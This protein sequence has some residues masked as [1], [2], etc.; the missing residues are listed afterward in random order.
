MENK[1]E[2]GGSSLKPSVLVVDDEKRIRDGCQKALRT[3][4]YVV[5]GA[6]N[7]EVALEKIHKKHFDLVLLDLMMPGPSGLEVLPQIKEIDSDAVIIVITGYATLEHAIEAMKKGAFDFIAKPFTPDQLRVVASKA[8]EYSRALQDIA[9]ERSRVRTLIDRLAEGVVTTDNE[10]RIVL[11]N[12]SFL[13]MVGW[14]K[15]GDV[16]NKFLAEVTPQRELMDMMDKVLSMPSDEFAELTEE[17]ELNNGEKKVL[18]A[19]C[20]PFR[21]R[22]GRTL[23]A[24]TVLHDITAIREMDQLKSSFVSMVS[25]EI[26]SPMNSVLAQLKVVLDGLAGELT[27][28]QK[29]ILTRASQKI[30]GLS[31]LAA[32]LLDLARIEAGLVTQEKEKLDLGEIIEQQVAFYTEKAAEKNIDLSLQPLPGLP[33]VLGSK[34]NLEEVLSNLIS[35][36]IKYSPE[37]GR[38]TVSAKQEDEF[39]ELKVSDTGYGIPEEDLERIFEKFY[40]VKNEDTRGISGTGLGLAIVKSIVEAHNGTI[41][42]ESELGKGTTFT[43]FLPV[44]K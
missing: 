15:K 38:V 4:G 44:M 1:M 33:P 27:P 35:N 16:T 42:V 31:E 24:V 23:G 43:V 9:E 17:L 26:Q 12:P 2:T 40:R 21:D 7:G 13:R 30:K 14:K 5:D 3:K 34:Y 18:A 39:I 22:I 28:K 36:A 19:R 10:K 6:E 29:D 20:V 25:H 8:I 32:E 37:G 41:E 11:A